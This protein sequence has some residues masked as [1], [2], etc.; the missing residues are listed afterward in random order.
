[1]PEVIFDKLLK[2]S[3]TGKLMPQ[4]INVMSLQT[5]EGV[6]ENGAIR[7]APN[8]H[9]PEKARVYVLVA[10]MTAASLIASPRLA[11]REDAKYFEMEIIE[12][13]PEREIMIRGLSPL[14]PLLHS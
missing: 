13:T 9:L 3:K 12:G 11:H 2:C 1:L 4:N 8:V 7:L 14:P 5:F 6:V 10:N